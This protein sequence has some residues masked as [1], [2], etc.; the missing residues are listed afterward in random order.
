MT[1]TGAGRAAPAK[2]AAAAAT[3]SKLCSLGGRGLRWQRLQVAVP[4]LDCTAVAA[5]A[6]AATAVL[7]PCL[8][9]QPRPLHFATLL[10]VTSPSCLLI[11]LPH[12]CRDR[13]RSRST[14]SDSSSGGSSSSS[15]ESERGSPERSRRGGDRDR[16]GRS[17]RYSSEERDRDRHRDR[18]GGRGG[19]GG[20]RYRPPERSGRDRGYEDRDRDRVRGRGYGDGRG[21]R[22][23][24]HEREERE[25]GSDQE[26]RRGGRYEERVP[27]RDEGRGQRGRGRDGGEER[28]SGEGRRSGEERRREQAK[29][30]CSTRG[31]W[32]SDCP[33]RMP[34]WACARGLGR[35]AFCRASHCE[36]SA[37]ALSN[38][39]VKVVC[40]S[41]APAALH[42]GVR[43]WIFFDQL[44]G[45]VLLPLDL[46]W[47]GALRAVGSLLLLDLVA[48]G[49]SMRTSAPPKPALAVCIAWHR[50]SIAVA[51][52]GQQCGSLTLLFLGRVCCRGRAR[53]IGGAGTPQRTAPP[54]PP[55]QPQRR[56]PEAPAPPR[57]L[58]S[59][60]HGSARSWRRGRLVACTSHPSSW[61][62]CSL[63]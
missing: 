34:Q 52:A 37:L 5:T 26:G 62:P 54:P 3:G 11:C 10:Y 40:R 38:F 24:R 32:V 2:I 47:A 46:S 43:P 59:R 49:C 4:S 1:G 16:R 50:A 61:R 35:I 60:R 48:R 25:R 19:G 33:V 20:D 53:G 56:A 17:S 21:G 55:S 51:K 36:P 8:P 58:R 15:S 13:R 44:G 22:D 41:E 30:R 57:P 23:S 12:H 14:S 9:R 45:T 42:S 6:A 18:R 31:G 39:V 63:R 7:K 28:P 27:R 29:V